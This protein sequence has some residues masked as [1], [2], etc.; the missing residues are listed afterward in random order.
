MSNL[1]TFPGLGLS[2]QISRV[3]FT[4]GGVTIYW[5]GVILAL[6]LFL[7]VTFAFRHCTEFGID[8][9]RMIDV[10]AVGTVMAI[11][12]ARAYYVV[13]SPYEYESIWQM[14]DIRSGGI[15]IYGAIAGAFIF[16][17]LACKWRKVPVLPMIDLAAMG[18]LIGQG[19]GRW[20]NF[21]NQEAFGYNT[22]LPWGMYSEAT[23]AYLESSVVT[24]P[25]GMT[26]DPTLPVHPTFLYESIWCLTGF[27]L[28]FFYFKKRKFDGD[29]ALRYAIWYGLGRF[30]IEGLRT[31]SLLLVPALNLRASQLVAAVTVV[32]A[33]AAQLY[34]TR[35]AKASQPLMVELAITNDTLRQLR[36]ADGP[37]G[38]I[39][40]DKVR[41][42]PVNASREEFAAATDEYNKQLVE[43]VRRSRQ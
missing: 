27:A 33:L 41:K 32:L 3:A 18:F 36:Q 26:I 22:T 35:K 34:L 23:R 25:A 17:G 15:A 8:S 43:A 12:C 42:C 6:G 7:G 30:W 24:L 29:V 5:Y 21:V 38:V 11:V 2:F 39:L 28:L 10:I 31:D 16:G 20:G 1:V 14:I 13:M 9:D 40:S 19:V 4:I 37:I